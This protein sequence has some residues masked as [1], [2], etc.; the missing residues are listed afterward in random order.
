[1]HPRLVKNL[2]LAKRADIMESSGS[3]PLPPSWL[4]PTAWSRSRDVDELPAEDSE[5]DDGLGPSEDPDDAPDTTGQPRFEDDFEGS[6]R[7]R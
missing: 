1:L 4:K 2:A 5:F 6:R 3:V 7:D